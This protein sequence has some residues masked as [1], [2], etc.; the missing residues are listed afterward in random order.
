VNDFE[1][2]P[3]ISGS[4]ILCEGEDLIL[5]IMEGITT[6]N[7]EPPTIIW[8][9]ANNNQPIDTTNDNRLQLSNVSPANSGVYYAVIFNRGCLSSASNSIE[10]T[11]V[12]RTNLVASAGKDELLC[13]A[14]TIDLAAL[15]IENTTG[16]W[17]SPTGAIIEDPTAAATTASNLIKGENIFVWTISDV[18]RQTATDTL[19]V[20]VLRTSGDVSD[21]GIDQNICEARTINLNA[22][23]LEESTGLWSQSL[24][25]FNQG[26]SFTNPNDPNTAVNGLMP[27]NIIISINEEPEE[28]AFIAEENANISICEGTQATLMAETPL[29][30]TGRWTT[31]S[32]VQI[33]NPTLAETMVG[34]LTPG[35]H[36]FI[37]TL[38]N[39]ACVDFS[40][41]TVRIY[42]EAELL[43]NPDAYTLGLEDSTTF[44]LLDNDVFNNFEN[45]RLT[46]T[47]FPE[48]GTLRDDGNGQFT[49]FSSRTVFGADDFRYKLCSNFCES[50]CD[51]AIVDLTI[52]GFGA[53]NDC[54]IP[55]I[56][57]PNGDN[58]NDQFLVGCIDQF[59]DASIK[60]F[61]RWGD[62]VHTATPYLNDWEGTYKGKPLP[63]GT[64]F[65]MLQLTPT[66]TPIQD[67]ITI[68]R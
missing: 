4:T 62:I 23:A 11:V 26:V 16:N 34:N 7:D 51:T 8:Y 28:I 42:R 10:V 40:S 45:L 43:A 39:E 56:L 65:Y 9:N 19:L 63:A 32:E 49:F 64:Y 55:N 35:E 21:A 31:T 30:S 24:D 54:F 3:T 53:G 2:V 66:S 25:Q 47:K 50:L 58:V 46:I 67:F 14:N 6:D 33:V 48:K 22:T 18:C 61:N 29:F 52:Q 44:N 41:D 59:P 36:I 57:S 17:T 27:G 5:E 38:S 12:N 37:W 68:F 13:T 1:R 15:S 20:T 60:I